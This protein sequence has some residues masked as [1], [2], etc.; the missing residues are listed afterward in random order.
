MIDV[1][2]RKLKQHKENIDFHITKLTIFDSQL[3]LR[4]VLFN[5]T[6]PAEK[7]IESE[8]LPQIIQN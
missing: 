2:P 5:S 6:M 4:K 7:L 1:E 8:T 3:P